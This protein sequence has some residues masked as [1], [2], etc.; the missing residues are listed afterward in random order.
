M[1]LRGAFE[2]ARRGGLDSLSMPGLAAHLNVGVTSIYW[3]FRSKEDLLQQM[4]LSAAQSFYDRLVTPDGFAPGDWRNYL[5]QLFRQYRSTLEV[6]ELF[7]ELLLHP[8]AGHS[9]VQTPFVYDKLE[10]QLAYL[11]SAGFTPRTAWN[12]VACLVMFTRGITT[13]ERARRNSGYPPEGLEQLS[14]I[15]VSTMPLLAGLVSDEG[16]SIDMSG[17]TFLP[18]LNMILDSAEAMLASGQ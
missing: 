5:Y 3:Y 16:V 13:S 11:V 14:R 7:A 6:D 10:G 1:I 4:Y 8:Q 12:T 9:G 18:G 2:V 17:D 15:D